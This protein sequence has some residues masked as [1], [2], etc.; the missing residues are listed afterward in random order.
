MEKE[1]RTLT[2]GQVDNQIQSMKGKILTLIDSSI[3]DKQQNKAVKDLIHDIIG[4]T[5]NIFWRWV[6]G[7]DVFPHP[8]TDKN[9]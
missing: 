5:R 3:I 1:F 6:I 4:E 9:K 2:F 8:T 7:E